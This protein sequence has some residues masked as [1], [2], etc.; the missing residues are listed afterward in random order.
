[1]CRLLLDAQDRAGDVKTLNVTITDTHGRITVGPAAQ[2]EMDNWTAIETTT[3]ERWWLFNAVDYLRL[4][5]HTVDVRVHGDDW[6]LVLTWS[7]G[8]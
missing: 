5:G 3:A 2:S 6:A 1:V 4:C 7:R 8:Q